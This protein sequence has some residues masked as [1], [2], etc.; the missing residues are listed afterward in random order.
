MRLRDDS[1]CQINNDAARDRH[2][3]LGKILRITRNGGIPV[4]NPYHGT[5]SARCNVT[6]RTEPGKM[7]QETFASG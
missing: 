5:D 1:G 4:D 2:V 6:G 3:L 7:C